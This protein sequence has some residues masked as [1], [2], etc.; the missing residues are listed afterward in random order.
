MS[1]WSIN[2]IYTSNV[3]INMPLWA[4]IILLIVLLLVC[5]IFAGSE[6]IFS[7][8]NKYHFKAEAEKGNTLA[9]VVTFLIN[10]FDNTLITVLIVNN[11]IQ[12]VMSLFM[13]S[14]ILDICGTSFDST[15]QSIIS[16]ILLSF[17]VF[18]ITD[19]LF[20]ILGK[21]LPNRLATIFGYIVIFFYF[22]LFPLMMIFKFVLVGVHKLFKIKDKNFLT[23]EDFIKEA[24]KAVLDANEEDDEEVKEELL[25]KD[26]LEILNK[27]F[28]FDEIKV[29]DVLKKKEEVFS[30][31]IK[32]LTATKLNKIILTHD[33]SR[34]PVYENKKDNIIGIITVRTYFKEYMEDN[35]LDIRSCLTEPLFFKVGTKLDDVF[36]EF[37]KSK[38]HIGIVK[39]DKNKVVG[40]VTMD[41]I[42]EELVGDINEI[43]VN[44]LKEI[45]YGP[46]SN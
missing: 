3:N 45:K 23:R 15:L 25:E 32:N 10:H 27:A 33:Y 20:K 30:V 40:I 6:N 37:N 21:H 26:E 18:I 12:Y 17:F 19:S 7:S 39:N 42:L 34:I 14:I 36:D 24:D 5:G 44:K 43:K 28:T 46:K 22:I 1:P 4:K 31:N 16:S 2:F 9:K 8:C 38:I 13:S 41:D 29:E 11:A 35:H